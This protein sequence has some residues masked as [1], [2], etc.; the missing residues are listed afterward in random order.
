M[1]IS[2]DFGFYPVP[3][4]IEE[5]LLDKPHLVARYLRY[6]RYQMRT[7]WADGE[8]TLPYAFDRNGYRSAAYRR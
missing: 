6:I 3:P 5:K 7:A 4:V 2:S 8:D 1:E